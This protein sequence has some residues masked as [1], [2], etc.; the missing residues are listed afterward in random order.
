MN[1]KLARKFIPPLEDAVIQLKDGSTLVDLMEVLSERKCEIKF[2]NVASKLRVHQIDNAQKAL[3][4]VWDSGVVMTLKPS[5]E[6]LVDG[7]ERSVS[8]PLPFSFLW[9]MNHFALISSYNGSMP[10]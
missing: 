3:N 4:F 2:T 1:Q 9:R 7:D 10:I 5:V 8:Y 6:N